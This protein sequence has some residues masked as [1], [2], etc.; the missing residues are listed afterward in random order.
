MAD[1]RDDGKRKVGGCVGTGLL[2][3]LVL[4]LGLV[5][6][7]TFRAGGEPEI[8]IEPSARGIG[9]RTPI[10]VRL[11]AGGRGLDDVH[12]QLVQGDRV[13]PV[14][15]KEYTP[16]PAWAF[17]GP[18]TTE[19]TLTVEVGRETVQNLRSGEA[20]VRVIAERPGTWLRDPD[21]V[22]AEVT[23]PVRLTPPSLS[24]VSTQHYVTQGGAEVVVYRVGDTA[25]RSGVEAGDWWFPGF[26]LPGGAAGERFALFAVPYDLAD[27]N[28]VKLVAVDDV[29][30]RAEAAFIDRSPRRRRPKGRSSSPTA[31]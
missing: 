5:G 12:V 11:A 13:E 29:G 19:D 22:V 10:E 3:V 24:V 6:L 30:N 28:R 16:R 20:T 9:P 15:E 31:S 21:P 25:E 17:W 2:V 7:A 18:R 4:V 1:Y 8:A 27:P 23:L 14:A 26:A